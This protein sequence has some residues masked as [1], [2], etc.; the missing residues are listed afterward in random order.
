MSPSSFIL[1]N[2]YTEYNTVT[3]TSVNGFSGSVTLSVN[4]FP[5]GVSASASSNP[6]TVPA[7][8]SATV[9]IYWTAS[10]RAPDETTTIE[11]IGTSGSLTNEIPVTIT[12]EEP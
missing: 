9:T 7:N 12:V 2:G 3:I 10:N 5:S 6:V 1:Y 4:E 8:G 11:F